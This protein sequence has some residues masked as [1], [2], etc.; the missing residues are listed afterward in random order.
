MTSRLSTALLGLAVLL[1][2]SDRALAQ[3]YSSYVLS[4]DPLFYWNFDEAGN[5]DPAIDLVGNDAGDNLIAEGNATRVNSG[6]TTG[7]VSLGR[8]ASFDNTQLTKF[9]S[10]TLSPTIDPTGY[11]IEMWVRPQP[12][13]VPGRAHYLLEAR[14]AATNQPSIIFD[15]LGPV[16]NNVELYWGGRTGGVGPAL[17]DNT[18]QHLVIGYYGAA[19]S[20]I[21]FYLNGA[22]AGSMVDLGVAPAFGTTQIA[23]GNSVPGHPDFDHFNG[24]IDELAVYDVTGLTAAAIEAKLQTVAAHYSFSLGGV[25]GDADGDNDV[26]EFD[27]FL[28]SDNLFTNQTPGDGGDLDLSGLVDFLDFRIWKNAANPALAA[29]YAIPEPTSL[30]LAALGVAWFAYRRRVG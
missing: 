13:S 2:A 29:Q 18:W 12:T 10:G 6:S 24:Q 25:I 23:V 14:G 11:I 15:Y 20:R 1:L 22:P 26:D 30:A 7:G 21:D 3:S 4:G 8:A 9:Y 19:A 28:I 16:D 17:V 5:T 27:F